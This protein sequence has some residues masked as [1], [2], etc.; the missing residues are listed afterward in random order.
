[1]TNPDEQRR[2]PMW[3]EIGKGNGSSVAGRR[4]RFS[5]SGGWAVNVQSRLEALSPEAS[6]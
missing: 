2:P 6:A 4:S 5:P 3:R 1:M